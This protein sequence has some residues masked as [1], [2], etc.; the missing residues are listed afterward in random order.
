MYRETPVSLMDIA[1]SFLLILTSLIAVSILLYIVAPFDILGW[2]KD[3]LRLYE[4]V[5]VL[6]IAFIVM[7]V[8]LRYIPD[9]IRPD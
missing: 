8:V 1:A 9:V 7:Y 6:I 2:A 3:N 4:A 5:Y